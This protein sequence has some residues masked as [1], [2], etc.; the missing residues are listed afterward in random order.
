MQV[1]DKDADLRFAII[2]VSK[3]HHRQESA[4]KVTEGKF[5]IDAKAGEDSRG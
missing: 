2:G 4:E 5:T 3:A 1:W